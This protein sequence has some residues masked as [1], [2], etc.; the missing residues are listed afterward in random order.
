MD[1]IMIAE[2]DGWLMPAQPVL[3]P[4]HF[5]GRE[6]LYAVSLHMDPKALSASCTAAG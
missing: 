4:L 6:R 3:P 5:L 1:L 2:Q